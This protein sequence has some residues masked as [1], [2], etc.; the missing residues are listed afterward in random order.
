MSCFSERAEIPAEDPGERCRKTAMELTI[1]KFGN[2][3]VM[4]HEPVKDLGPGAQSEGSQLRPVL[5]MLAKFATKRMRRG[6]EREDNRRRLYCA[7][8][9]HDR[10]LSM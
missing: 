1:G 6:E 4:N 10:T 5:G 9:V 2:A 8:T 7:S 3:R